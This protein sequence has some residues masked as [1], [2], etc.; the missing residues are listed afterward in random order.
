M[1]LNIPIG[2]EINQTNNKDVKIRVPNTKYW[3]L[4]QQNPNKTWNAYLTDPENNYKSILRK[5]T[6]L[7]SF[8]LFSNIVLKTPFPYQGKEAEDPK[9]IKKFIKK[10]TKHTYGKHKRKSNISSKSRRIQD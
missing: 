7:K 10:I 5:E 1:Q 9:E 8:I 6:T 2:S 4:G 3:I